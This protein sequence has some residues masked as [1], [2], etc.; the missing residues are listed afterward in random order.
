MYPKAIDILLVDD[1]PD[2]VELALYALRRNQLA[3]HIQIAHD[4]VEALDFLFCRGDYSERDCE[5]KPKMILLDLNM[6][7]VNG[8]EVLKAIRENPRTAGIPVVILTTSKEDRDLVESYRLG[9]NS[10]IVK[11][12]DFEQFSEVVRQLGYYWLLLNEHP[13]VKQAI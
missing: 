12:V 9:V 7:K 4:G 1:N 5:L 6:P 8:L 2:D 3:N 11:P 10:Y 13:R